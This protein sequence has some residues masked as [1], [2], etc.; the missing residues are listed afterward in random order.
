[1]ESEVFS[2]F[3]EYSRLVAGRGAG[4]M[5]SGNLSPSPAEGVCKYCKMGGSCNFAVGREGAER[6]PSSIKCERIAQ[7]AKGENKDA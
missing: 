2:A 4:E 1:M 7:I 5:L 3:L 6:K